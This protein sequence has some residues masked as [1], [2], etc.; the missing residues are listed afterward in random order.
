ME[1]FC[2]DLGWVGGMRFG[3]CYLDVSFFGWGKGGGW[4]FKVSLVFGLVCCFG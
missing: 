1:C 3:F 4:F 2:E